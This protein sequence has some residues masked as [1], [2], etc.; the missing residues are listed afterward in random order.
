MVTQDPTAKKPR[1]IPRRAVFIA[2]ILGIVTTQALGAPVWW[3]PI[4][5]PVI[6]GPLPA[7]LADA[8]GPEQG[9]PAPEFAVPA[10]GGGRVS[11]AQYAGH[12]RVVAFFAVGCVDCRPDL[13]ALEQAYRR[14]RHQGLVVLGIDVYDTS[15]YARGLANLVRATFPIGYDERGDLA[16]RPYRLSIVPTTVFVDAHGVIR[17]VHEGRV[18]GAVLSKNLALILP[19]APPVQ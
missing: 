5:T 13:A 6:S 16:A 8:A 9:R 17:A 2:L 19:P 11:L 12:P 1:S 4:L 7:A 3:P 14:Y 18:T 15:E 10:I